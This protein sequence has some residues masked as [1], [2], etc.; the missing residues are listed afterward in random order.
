[1]NELR[2][3][4]QSV[5]DR[6]YPGYFYSGQVSNPLAVATM[7][8]THQA[9]RDAMDNMDVGTVIGTPCGG[10]KTTTQVAIL[11]EIATTGSVSALTEEM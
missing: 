11:K 5:Q 7:E 10:G 6:F 3:F 2:T 8:H 9:I 1:M 4:S